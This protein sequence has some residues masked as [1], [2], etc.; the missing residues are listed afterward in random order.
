MSPRRTAK[1]GSDEP[2][3]E[4]SVVKRSGK[5]VRTSRGQSSAVSTRTAP[6]A[7]SWMGQAVL[8][9]EKNTGTF[10]VQASG[11]PLLEWTMAIDEM[12]HVASQIPVPPPTG[13]V[14]VSKL[15]RVVDEFLRYVGPQSRR[16]GEAD[17]APEPVPF[18]PPR[19]ITFIG[20]ATFDA[21][22]QRWAIHTETGDGSSFDWSMSMA[23]ARRI[24]AQLPLGAVAVTD[25]PQPRD[26]LGS[27]A[28]STESAK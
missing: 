3:K 15:D 9:F 1:Y 19:T 23:K 10:L 18:P 4:T 28:S 14:S 20:S 24:R 16:G 12:H 21:R 8:D 17:V 6:A 11:G 13:S 5:S 22:R 25:A 27:D 26:V 2:R 7:S